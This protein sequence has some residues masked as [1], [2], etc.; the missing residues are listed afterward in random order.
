MSI[1]NSMDSIRSS[2]CVNVLYCIFVPCFAFVLFLS[3]RQTNTYVDR[4][5]TD[6][7]ENM[8]P[9]ALLNTSCTFLSSLAM[10]EFSCG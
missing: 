8:L 10:V 4:H 5:T 9:L 7:Y 2:T 3:L 1:I 6:I